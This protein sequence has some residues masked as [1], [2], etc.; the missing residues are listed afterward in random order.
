[1]IIYSDYGDNMVSLFR[2]KGRALQIGNLSLFALVFF[3]S[4]MLT[5][6]VNLLPVIYLKSAEN[7]IR[8]FF[9]ERA[10][11]VNLAYALFSYFF[12]FSVFGAINLGI[13]RFFLKKAQKKN[14]TSQD[15]FFY[16]KP[17]KFFRYIFYALRINLIRLAIFV[18]C[19]LPCLG[20]VCLLYSFS[21]R[22]VSALVCLSL[23]VT[24]VC[25][26]INGVIFYSSFFSSFFLCDYCFIEGSFVSFSHLIAMSQKLMC[27]R[28]SL[29]TKLKLSFGGWFIFCFLIIPIPFVWSYYNQCL[30]VAAADFMKENRG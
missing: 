22:G 20:C 1:M 13:K 28:K 12:V 27:G 19:I 25:L 11:Y 24:A 6:T 8:E 15:I 5:L 7:Y 9:G 16:F 18:F 29:L 17:K 10:V 26:F 2:L 3:T 21:S 4:V 14:F 30:A 23:A